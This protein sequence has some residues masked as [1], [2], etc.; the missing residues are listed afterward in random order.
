MKRIAYLTLAFCFG[1][2]LCGSVKPKPV[3]I[4]YESILAQ[5]R[6]ELRLK[7][8]EMMSLQKKYMLLSDKYQALADHHKFLKKQNASIDPTKK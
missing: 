1:L 7:N 2:L 6:D 4:D 5:T 8:L 3:L